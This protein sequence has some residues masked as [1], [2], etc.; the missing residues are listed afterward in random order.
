M[1]ENKNNS[2]YSDKFDSELSNPLTSQIKCNTPKIQYI[3]NQSSPFINSK[4]REKN[5]NLRE[6]VINTDIK[7]SNLN[8]KRHKIIMNNALQAKFN[9]VYYQ[10]IF[11]NKKIT[12]LSLNSSESEEKKSNSSKNSENENQGKE[13][14]IVNEMKKLDKIKIPRCNF[15][16]YNNQKIQPLSRKVINKK[17]NIGIYNITINKKNQNDLLGRLKNVRRAKNYKVLDTKNEKRKITKS[18]KTFDL[19]YNEVENEFANTPFKSK[20]NKQKIV[21]TLPENKKDFNFNFN[22]D[23][24]KKYDEIV[25]PDISIVNGKIQTNYSKKDDCIIY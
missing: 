7:D 8:Q 10:R 20:K 24:D 25:I 4:S 3:S 18:C 11:N 23:N 17:Q 9:P 21:L 22:F 1:S 15:F 6:E 16:L 5:K 2:L 19:K 13:K 12:K 14:N